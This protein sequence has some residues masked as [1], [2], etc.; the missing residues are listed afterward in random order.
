[1]PDAR[2]AMVALA[3]LA[4]VVLSA[5]GVTEDPTAPR[6][7]IY[8]RYVPEQTA[9]AAPEGSV[10][11]LYLLQARA[12]EPLSVTLTGTCTFGNVTVV[13]A[14]D[15]EFSRDG[16]PSRTVE[17]RSAPLPPE[18]LPNLMLPPACRF[19]AVAQDGTPVPVRGG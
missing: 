18:R 13:V 7:I 16:S 4:L 11:I 2:R 9:E 10:V 19:E 6:E 3:V 12:S 5:C 14:N 1:M 15:V 8:G 17:L